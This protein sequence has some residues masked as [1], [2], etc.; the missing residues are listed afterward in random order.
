MGTKKGKGTEE[1]APVEKKPEPGIIPFESTLKC[2]LTDKELQQKGAE[3]ADAI[4][5]G[6]RL[7]AEFTEVKQ[8]FKGKID[9]AT[10]RV[11]ALASTIRAKS[12]YRSVKCSRVFDFEAGLVREIRTDTY[13]EIGSRMMTDTDRQQHL[14]LALAE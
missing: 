7:E 11:A 5:E 4:D 9:G 2:V 6:K 14:P 13:E 12:E 3:L 8:Q 10:G 1:V